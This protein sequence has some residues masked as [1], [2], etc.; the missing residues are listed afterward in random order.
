MASDVSFFSAPDQRRK[1]SRALPPPPI[2]RSR[3]LSP[4]NQD[5]RLSDVIGLR[6]SNQSIPDMIGLRQGT[7]NNPR[8][9]VRGRQEF[10]DSQLY[11]NRSGRAK[12]PS[13]NLLVPGSSQMI[14]NE[15]K[16]KRLA[17]RKNVSSSCF[18]ILTS[19]LSPLVPNILLALYLQQRRTLFCS[20]VWEEFEELVCFC[21][22]TLVEVI[23][24]EAPRYW[25]DNDAFG[26]CF[27]FPSYIAQ[28]FCY[29][30]KQVDNEAAQLIKE[31]GLELKK[32]FGENSRQED[33]G[34]RDSRQSRKAQYH[35]KQENYEY[36]RP[37]RMS[38]HPYHG[39]QRVRDYSQPSRKAQY[40]YHGRK[41]DYEYSRPSRISQHQ[42]AYGEQQRVH[43]YSQPSR[44]THH[45]YQ[46]Q[47]DHGYTRQSR[48]A[49][50]Q[51]YEQRDAY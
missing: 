10:R 30:L 45:Q 20:D 19:R 37:S 8:Q 14:A 32:S 33:R 4:S 40:Q 25:N 42:Y 36:S 44:L 7:Q 26:M 21:P 47:R 50:H 39:E 29:D 16:Q 2:R 5:K 51:Y 31:T 43:G 13:R 23:D 11:K 35:G 12:S 3:S 22:N 46:E 18:T 38:Q 48:R 27:T 9:A 41:D 6:Q 28:C 15:R 49:H 24:S 1:Q 17:R 34:R